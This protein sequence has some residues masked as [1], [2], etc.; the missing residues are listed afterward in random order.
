MISLPAKRIHPRKQKLRTAFKLGS[1]EKKNRKLVWCIHGWMFWWCCLG[2]P[3]MLIILWPTS[4]SLWL[5]QL[6]LRLGKDSQ[7]HVWFNRQKN[8]RKCCN[9]KIPCKI[10]FELTT[11]KR[12][13]CRYM[14]ALLP[15]CFFG[16]INSNALHIGL[17]FNASS[18]RTPFYCFEPGPYAKRPP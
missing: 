18:N 7:G 10:T 1:G 9:P 3:P 13:P 8:H 6:C 16:V 12:K 2:I 14:Y 15:S 5:L 4:F 11:A 17:Q